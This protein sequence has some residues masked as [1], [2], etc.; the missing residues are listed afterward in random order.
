MYLLLSALARMQVRIMGLM[1]IILDQIL[2][3]EFF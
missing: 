1:A 2:E 3:N